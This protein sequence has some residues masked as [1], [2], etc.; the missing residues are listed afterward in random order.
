M[1]WA[2]QPRAQYVG[3]RLIRAMAAMVVRAPMIDFQRCPLGGLRA[4]FSLSKGPAISGC[5]IAK[6]AVV[7]Q[8]WA[9]GAGLSVSLES[10]D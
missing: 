8:S 7:V 9:Q 1:L 3:D 4:R 5:V 10:S 2:K 6:S